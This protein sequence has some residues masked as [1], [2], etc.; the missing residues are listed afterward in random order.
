LAKICWLCAK[1]RGV[2]C[3]AGWRTT[4][5][6]IGAGKG[7]VWWDCVS[8]LRRSFSENGEIN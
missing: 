8:T 2:V 6:I 4:S 1:V 3:G 5:G 7:V